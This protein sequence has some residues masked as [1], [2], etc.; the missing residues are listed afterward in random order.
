MQKHRLF[1]QKQVWIVLY[2]IAF[3]LFN[4]VV[5]SQPETKLIA[6]DGEGGDSFGQSV[7]I[8]G[9]FAVVGAYQDND[10]GGQAGAAYIFKRTGGIWTEVYKL[11]ASDGDERDRFGASVAISGDYI[12]IGAI[13]DENAIIGPGAGS[14]YVFERNGGVWNEVAK[15]IASD[16]APGASFGGT[17]AIDGNYIIIGS[18]ANKSVSNFSSGAAYIF[19]RNAGVWTEVEKL[20]PLGDPT[21]L[22][23]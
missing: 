14:A 5:Y 6:G 12:V 4:E 17:V 9:N 18:H 22:L 23:I 16:A 8:D 3:L 7:S 11:T 19:E 10:R 15:L 13:Q 21:P 20:Y 2:M 1:I